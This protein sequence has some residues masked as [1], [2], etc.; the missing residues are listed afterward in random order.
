MRE[1]FRNSYLNSAKGEWH[2][3]GNRRKSVW[4]IRV[5]QHPK[6]KKALTDKGKKEFRDFVVRKL[7]RQERRRFRSNLL[8][9]IDFFSV[10]KNPASLQ[11]MVK[12]YL[13]LLHK[14]MP[15]IDSHKE[16]LF[17]DDSQIKILIANH[18]PAIGQDPGII[19]F[20]YPEKNYLEDVELARRIS[21][22]DFGGSLLEDEDLN[23]YYDWEGFDLNDQ[24]L[25]K[26]VSEMVKRDKERSR[27]NQIW[28]L[29]K[30]DKESLFCLLSKQAPDSQTRRILL[31][32]LGFRLESFRTSEGG[33]N[34][35]KRLLKERLESQKKHFGI[36]NVIEP[37]GV[38]IVYIQPA[39]KG[40][41]VDLDNLIKKIDPL[42]K[43]IYEPPSNHDPTNP[44]KLNP[45]EISQYQVISMERFKDSPPEGELY[46]GLCHKG[47][48]D[49]HTII[50]KCIEGWEREL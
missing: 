3:Y 41:Q 25:P 50:D 18:Y 46:I 1:T 38:T 13:D 30:I 49:I 47:F 8:I 14:P 27:Q 39:D 23:E 5:N 36:N 4:V 9:Q 12:N 37:M 10:E 26:E 43:D 15:E 42:I 2:Q 31:Y 6:T 33:T 35:F 21:W 34:E 17:K 24:N 16:I 32:N 29:A 45:N 28:S 11:A 44:Q 19:I 40:H 22:G 7:R 20:A 48:K